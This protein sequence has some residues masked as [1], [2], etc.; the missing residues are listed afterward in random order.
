MDG[1]PRCTPRISHPAFHRLLAS[2]DFREAAV[3]QFTLQDVIEDAVSL[4][5]GCLVVSLCVYD[6]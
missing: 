4:V 3:A 1:P 5:S 2:T 6:A